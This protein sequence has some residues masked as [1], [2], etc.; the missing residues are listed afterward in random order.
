M[1]QRQ[2]EQAWDSFA[3]TDATSGYRIPYYLPAGY[4]WRIDKVIMQA[5]TQYAA[6]DTNY[7]TFTLEDSSGNDICQVVNGPETGGLAIGPNATGVTST[8]TS[9]YQD[10]DCRSAAS[11]VYL[12]T[13]ATGDGR[14]MVGVKAIVMATPRRAGLANL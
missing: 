2:F 6:Q 7:Q 14:A 3:T 8:M 9:A 5:Q 4:I 11:Y 12:T 13:A 10:I 1:Y